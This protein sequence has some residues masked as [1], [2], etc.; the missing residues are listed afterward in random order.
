MRKEQ[1]ND[2]QLRQEV[3]NGL[4]RVDQTQAGN[5]NGESDGNR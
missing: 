5:T 3:E 2:T 1:E 4:V